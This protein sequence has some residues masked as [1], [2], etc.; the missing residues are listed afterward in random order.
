MLENLLTLWRTSAAGRAYA[1]LGERDRLAVTG[2]AAFL[3]LVVIYLAIWRP[4]A[5]WQDAADARYQRQLGVLEWMR[6]HETEARAAAR[7]ADA[8]RDG[9]NSML[10]VVSSTAN[11]AG[12]KLTRF[13]PEGSGG[14]SVVIQNQPF[15]AVLRWLDDLADEGI[16]VRTLSI[17][18]QGQNGLIN[19]RINLI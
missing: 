15:N 16:D 6:A 1:Q 4:I 17:D 14:V 13:Q 7:G 9:G 19:G 11:R 10:S 2:L 12:V 3:A 5:A 18:R 8:Q